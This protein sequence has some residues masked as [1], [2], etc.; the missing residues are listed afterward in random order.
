MAPEAITL[1]EIIKIKT[2][3]KKSMYGLKGDLSNELV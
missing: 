2:T 1:K 3:L